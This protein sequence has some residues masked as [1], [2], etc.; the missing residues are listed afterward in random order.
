MRL[1]FARGDVID[2]ITERLSTL[3]LFALIR[4]G[5]ETLLGIVALY[6]VAVAAP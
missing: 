5:T 4:V 1:I 2:V 6:T 3:I